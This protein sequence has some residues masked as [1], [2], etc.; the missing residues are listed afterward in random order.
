MLLAGKLSRRVVGERLGHVWD[1]RDC[2]VHSGR[3]WPRLWPR[4]RPRSCAGRDLSIT[5]RPAGDQA[6]TGLEPPCPLEALR[7]RLEGPR[8]IS[9]CIDASEK[10]FAPGVAKSS[11]HA[12]LDK[13]ALGGHPAQCLNQVRHVFRRVALEAHFLTGNGVHEAENGRV[14]SLA[15]EGLRR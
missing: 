13:A 9:T 10:T 11:R 3:L 15:R 7:D 1:R 8:S 12:V 4:L 14:Q 2:S 5:Q 6:Q